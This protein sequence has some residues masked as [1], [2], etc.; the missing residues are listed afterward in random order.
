MRRRELPYTSEVLH[1]NAH[2]CPMQS[3]V[4]RLLFRHVISQECQLI[5]HHDQWVT[6]N[7][8]KEKFIFI[9]SCTYCLLS[10]KDLSCRVMKMDVFAHRFIF[11]SLLAPESATKLCKSSVKGLVRRGWQVDC[12]DGQAFPDEGN[13]IK[14]ASTVLSYVIFLRLVFLHFNIS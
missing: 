3:H 6:H 12:R 4:S 7:L 10:S 11:M 1:I 13:K 8:S 14:Y 2:I 5:L 9:K